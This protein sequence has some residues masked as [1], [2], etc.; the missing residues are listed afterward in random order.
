MTKSSLVKKADREFSKYWREKIGRCERCGRQ[1][2]LQLCHI[3]TRNIRKLRFE[4]K[5]TFV[6]CA[7]CHRNFHNKPLE[8]SDFVKEKKGEDTAKWLIRESNDLKPISIKFYQDV[9]IK[10]KKD[11]KNREANKKTRK[12]DS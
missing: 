3:I 2:N 5:N 9:I 1:E 7:S 4:R 11:E 12:N 10:L 6:L 8:F